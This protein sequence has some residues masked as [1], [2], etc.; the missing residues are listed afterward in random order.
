MIVAPAVTTNAATNVNGDSAT[1]N[2][3]ITDIGHENCD[4]RGFVWD[5]ETHGDPGDVAPDVSA[6]TW[7]TLDGGSFGVGAFNESAGG[8][9]A[10]TTYYFRAFAHN[11]AGYT[12]GGELT[13][14]TT[15]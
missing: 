10:E 12:Y 13:F 6:Y 7:Y 9:S 3:E 15:A 14:T 8:L 4:K 2:G 5:D 1:L 11:S